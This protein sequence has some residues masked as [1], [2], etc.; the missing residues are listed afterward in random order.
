MNTGEKIAAATLVV[1]LLGLPAAWL[2]VPPFQDWAKRLFTP[3]DDRTSQVKSPQ[4]TQPSIPIETPQTTTIPTNQST[5]LALDRIT[6][7]I[8]RSIDGRSN[9][10]SE[11][12]NNTGILDVPGA[13][14]TEV[15]SHKTEALSFVSL[16]DCILTVSNQETKYLDHGPNFGVVIEVDTDTVSIPLAEI[17]V[18][19]GRCCEDDKPLNPVGPLLQVAVGDRM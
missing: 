10:K 18:G 3:H 19:A 14:V 7:E 15:L 12:I 1:A 6:E 2:A 11:W 16:S 4:V 9:I 17:Q 13:P 5:K 8:K